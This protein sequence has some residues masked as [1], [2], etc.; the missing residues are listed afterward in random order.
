MAKKIITAVIAVILIGAGAFYGGVKYA[1]NSRQN[2]SSQNLSGRNLT[3]EERQQRMQQMSSSDR[4]AGGQSGVNFISGEI[5]SKDDSAKSITVKI[6]DARLP[7]G[8]GGSKII[9]FSEST[10]I[11]KF[12]KGAAGDLEAGKTVA[13]SG[14]VNQDGSITAQS[15][16]VRPEPLKP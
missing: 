12:V 6:R 13:V 1:E 8:Q 4:M 14:K 9:F 11:G 16:Q 5:I 2:F 7:G 15:V 10:E 3:P